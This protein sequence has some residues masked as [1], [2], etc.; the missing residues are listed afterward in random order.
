M[1][2]E[3][4]PVA[5]PAER[6]LD[7]DLAARLAGADADRRAV[8]GEDDRVRA[9]VPDRAPG[10]EQVGQLLERRPALGHDLEPAAVEPEVVEASRPAGRRRRA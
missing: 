3:L 10:E 4:R 9:D 8:A 6:D 7:R 1:H 2:G 5:R